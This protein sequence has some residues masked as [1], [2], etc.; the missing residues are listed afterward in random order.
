MDAKDA[1]Q[2]GGVAISVA[3]VVLVVVLLPLLYV[4]SLGPAVWL[5]DHGYI[6]PRPV[7]IVYWP[8]ESL[9]QE[10]EAAR[11]ALTWYADFFR[12]RPLSVR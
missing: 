3:I 2:S 8:L 9:A 6:A 7:L 1:R 11:D 12:E 10:S 5:L 4:A